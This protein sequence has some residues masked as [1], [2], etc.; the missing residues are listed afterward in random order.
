MARLK[1]THPDVDDAFISG[2]D[3][4]RLQNAKGGRSNGACWTG[5]RLWRNE[6]C[7]GGI[8]LSMPLD[9]VR[10]SEQASGAVADGDGTFFFSS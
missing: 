2:H 1:I 9:D 6:P 5:E 10:R 8:M 3:N 7:L 4:R